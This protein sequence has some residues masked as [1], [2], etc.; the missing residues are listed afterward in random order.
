MKDLVA[1]P[2]RKYLR[3]FE[4]GGQ[5]V[6]DDIRTKYGFDGDLAH[7]FARGSERLVHK[8]H[9]YI[10]LY[11]RYFSRLRGTNAR[12]L[13]IGVSQGGSLDLWRSYFGEKA[14]IFGIDIDPDCAQFDGISGSVWIGSQNDLG[15]LDGVVSEMSGIDVV[16]DDGSH[17][18]DHIR[19]S[20][21]YLFPK[22]ARGG[23]YMIE[24]LQVAYFAEFGGGFDSDGNFFNELRRYADALHRNYHD[25]DVVPEFARDIS[26]V[27]VH[28]SIVV[29]DKDSV[30]APC[31][32]RVVGSGA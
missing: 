6:V 5:D 28:D 11:D 2:I 26:G 4:F 17:R 12:F 3:R 8:W 1:M 23:I 16:L 13:E 32:S 31:H 9:H 20:L 19:D 18:M 30:H 29:L 24:D 25:E 10:P 15:F 27:H 7:L 22:L 21:S 14:T